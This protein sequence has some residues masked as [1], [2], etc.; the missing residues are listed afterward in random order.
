MSVTQY[1]NRLVV[2]NPTESLN[3]QALL[4]W[5]NNHVV[6]ALI[7]G[8]GVT[9]TAVEQT[10]TPYGTP[11]LTG[12]ITVNAGGGGGGVTDITSTDGSVTITDP[13]GPTTDLSVPKKTTTNSGGSGPHGFVTV[14]LTD[15]VLLNQAAVRSDSATATTYSNV[16]LAAI[17]LSNTNAA[18]NVIECTLRRHSDSTILSQGLTTVAP[19]AGVAT[20]YSAMTLVAYDNVASTD[21]FDLYANA[22]LTGGG[23]KAYPFQAV[24]VQLG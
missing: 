2:P 17:T 22:Q 19:P 1:N 15:T 6:N 13:T 5:A 20:S 18:T 14:P 23:F 12:V 4:L 9:M 3:W 10:Q 7:P 8:T 24:G 21:S 16:I 11:P